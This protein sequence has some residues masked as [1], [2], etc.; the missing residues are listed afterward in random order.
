VRLIIARESRYAAALG[1]L[2]QLVVVLN[3]DLTDRLARE[4]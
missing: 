4:D 3:A 1:R 2:L